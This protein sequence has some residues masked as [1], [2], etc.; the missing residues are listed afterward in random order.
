[1]TNTLHAHIQTYAVDCDGP[2]S[3]G[4]TMT[5]NDNEKRSD[6]GDI[7]FHHRVVNRVVNTYSLFLTGS[8]KV[9]NEEDNGIRLVWSE[10]TEEGGRSIEALICK[11]EDCLS[12]G[13]DYWQRDH[14]AEEAGY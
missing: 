7:E 13:D 2:I 6:F 11:D 4:Y 1:M 5:V 3:S 8:L 10:T 9:T 14:R 12:D